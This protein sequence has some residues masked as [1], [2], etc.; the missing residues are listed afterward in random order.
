MMEIARTWRVLAG[1]LAVGVLGVAGFAGT[2]ASAEPVLP[3]PPNPAPAVTQT[4]SA[5]PGAVGNSGSGATPSAAPYPVS[6]PLPSATAG[7]SAVATPPVAPTLVPATSGTLR[8]YLQAKEVKLE[9]QKPQDFKALDI[10][11]PMPTGWTQVP[12]PNVPDAFAVIADRSGRSL[13][14][15]NAQVVV[16]KLI[17]DFDPKEAITHGYI[18]SQ[19][20]P[21]WQTTDASLADFDG[22]PSSI[23]EGTYRQNDMTLNTSR[24]YVIATS[25]QDKYLVSLAVTTDVTQAVA[26]APA[27]DAIVNGFRVTAPTPSP[28]PGPAPLGL[29]GLNPPPS[30]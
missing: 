22:F 16:Y 18:D 13:Y 15:S 28:P 26:E 10:S 29:P 17:G 8:D 3:P 23:I 27:T 20:L 21:A 14:T 30:R 6:S 7:P 12:D 19:Q 4:V 11:L 24:R 2:T 1:G 5:T 9:P 25:G